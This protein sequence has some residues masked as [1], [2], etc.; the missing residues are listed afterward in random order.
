VDEEVR[1]TTLDE[2][3]WLL[4]QLRYRD[5]ETTR[6]LLEVSSELS[7]VPL[8]FLRNEASA[9]GM[10]RDR[11]SIEELLVRA[12]R[13]GTLVIRRREVAP[14][15]GGEGPEAQANAPGPGPQPQ[16]APEPE[17]TGWI[18]IELVDEDGAP[19]PNAKYRIVLPDGGIRTGA[20]NAS[21]KGEVT[22]TVDG[23][24]SVSFPGLRGADG[25]LKSA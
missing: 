4:Y 17:L 23:V 13:N 18:A 2:L 9:W 21:G 1:R 6:V 25:V 7:H 19:V 22:K 16:D 15:G 11:P 14:G 10:G 3:S 8:S 5:P 20:T 24:C 12:A